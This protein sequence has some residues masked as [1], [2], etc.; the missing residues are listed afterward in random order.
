MTNFEGGC[1]CGAIRYRASGPASH[2]SYCHCTI[3]RR[4][5]GT[6][7]VSWPTVP[8]RS[9]EYMRGK[10]AQY[11]SSEF[12]YR[13]FCATCGSQLTFR[14]RSRTDQVDITSATLDNPAL[15]SPQDY[16]WTQSR[17]DWFQTD[18]SLSRYKADRARD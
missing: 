8:V 4:A 16:L 17:I 2:Q 7:V 14:D 6:P 11:D 15:A 3:C 10:S 5:C 13:E 9:F 12:A 1:L 18:D